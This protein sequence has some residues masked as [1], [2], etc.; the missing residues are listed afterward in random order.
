MHSN[1]KQDNIVQA[2]I[3]Q[4]AQNGLAATTMETI[5]S[6]AHVSKRTLYKHF[7]NKESLF[8]E[9]VN[10]LI[11]RINP[12]AT[13]QYIPNYGLET[14]LAHL[15][16]SA[17][18]LLA[19]ED[20]LTLSRIVM[21]ESMRNKEQAQRLSARFVNC[22]CALLQWFKDAGNEGSLGD[23]DPELAAAFFWGGL[24]KLTYWEQV[25]KWQAP[26]EEAKLDVLLQQA[27]ALF[28][29][30]VTPRQ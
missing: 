29:Q 24:K 13:I 2:A 27:V 5:A 1:D 8:D 23:V 22:E 17:A 3:A 18:S 28:C 11:S 19:D 4:F 16:R 12:L 10:R 21:I 14:Q 7:P 20:Y 15:A 26:L 25:L 9:V 6:K 30:G